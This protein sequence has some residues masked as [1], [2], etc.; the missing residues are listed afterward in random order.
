MRRRYS[1]PIAAAGVA[2]LVVV[3]FAVFLVLH[4]AASCADSVAVRVSA[5]PDIAPALRDAANAFVDDR[6]NVNGKCITISIAAA[7][8]ANVA[9]S[10]TVFSGA[11][12]DVAAKPAPTPTEEELPA[13]WVPDSTAWLRRVATVDRSIFVDDAQTIASSPVVLAM[14]DVAAKA[15]GWP[16]QPLKATVLKQLL[17]AG[18]SGI[19]LGI[20]EPRRETASLAATMLLGD[21]LASREDEL[22]GLVKTFRSVVHEASTADLLNAMGTSL[23]AA[24]ASEQA[25]IA[26]DTANPSAQLAGV[27]FDP[28]GP[29]LDYPYAIRA[30]IDSDVAAAAHLFRAALTSQ[31]YVQYLAKYGFRTPAGLA[32]DGFP[33][34]VLPPGALAGPATGGTGPAAVKGVPVDDTTKIERAIGL[35][36]AANSA[37]RTLALFDV[38]SSMAQVMATPAGSQTR[39]RVM[40]EAADQGLDLFTTDSEVGM[41]AFASAHQQV[42]SI[43]KLTPARK[44]LFDQ[45]LAGA[46]VQPTNSSPLYDTL[47]AAYQQMQNGFDP[48]R[49]NII[50]VLTDGGDSRPGG[51][52]LQQFQLSIQRLA[53]ATKPIRVVLIG[54]D[55]APGDAAD[56]T[57]IATAMGGGYY[58]LTSPD[59][60]QLIFLKALL[61]LDS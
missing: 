46:A 23:T 32:G 60:I 2:M 16:G 52:R 17:Q 43:D 28:A 11:G 40:A 39:L 24:P 31:E 59:Q 9:S 47:V 13:V 10:L 4:P 26:F 6:P 37:S 25:V 35:W 55:V 53:D 42:L 50:V 29:A 56:L 15:I 54:I 7:I 22:P 34:G 1:L 44:T 27:P 20:A 30:G 12:I 58:P 36:T 33:S 45:A 49:P 14:P 61:Q 5:S 41:W 21:V 51:Q 57:A 19:K 8:P 18:G 3:G 38:T 48:T